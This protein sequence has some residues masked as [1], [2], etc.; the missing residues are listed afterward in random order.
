[1]ES[2]LVTKP[3]NASLSHLARFIAAPIVERISMAKSQLRQRR[4]DKGERGW[5]FRFREL[6]NALFD[7]VNFSGAGDP[8][9]VACDDTSAAYRNSYV[10]ART[11]LLKILDELKPVAA[12]QGPTIVLSSDGERLLSVVVSVE[13]ERP[14]GKRVWCFLHFADE[15]LR[16][17]ARQFILDALELGISVDGAMDRPLAAVANVKRGEIEFSCAGD[18]AVRLGSLIDAL[19]QYRTLLA[20]FG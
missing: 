16:K 7:H 8:L 6:Q 18:D 11:G 14:G 5:T 20:M 12:R 1:V 19:R 17:A 13:F 3:I 2:G 9:Q 15:P 4:A 10:T